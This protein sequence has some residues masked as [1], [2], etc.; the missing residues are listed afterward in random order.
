MTAPGEGYGYPVQP[1]TSSIP[2][3]TKKHT[4]RNV[5]FVAI[6]VLI[7]VLIAAALVGGNKSNTT[8]TGSTATVT[9]GPTVTVTPEP[10]PPVTVI[11]TQ[12]VEV[13]LTA[14][15]PVATA[16][17]PDGISLVGVDIQPGTYKSTNP[18]CYFARLSD[19]SGG[20][21]GIITNGNGA[22]IITI[23]PA[24]KAF[25]SRRCAPWTVVG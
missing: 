13:T 16:D 21:A 15:P 18:D 22:T 3:P 1:P 5:A 2:P 19:T 14:P 10:P 17:I 6:A 9:V 8:A 11:Q 12:P 4:A 24:D 7:V 20:L 23:D 25:E